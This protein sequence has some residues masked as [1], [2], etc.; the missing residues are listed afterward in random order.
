MYPRHPLCE[1]VTLDL[2]DMELVDLSIGIEPGATSEPFPGSVEYHTH[3]DGAALLDGLRWI[4]L[5]IAPHVTSTG[6]SS[7]SPVPAWSTSTT[8]TA[9]FASTT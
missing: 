6:L 4:H 5:A 1:T 9:W 3:A 2:A 8:R 7:N